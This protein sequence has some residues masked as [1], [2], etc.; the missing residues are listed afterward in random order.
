MDDGFSLNMDVFYPA[1][2]SILWG[3]GKSFKTMCNSCMHISMNNFF[4]KFL[5]QRQREKKRSEYIPFSVIPYSFLSQSVPTCL[6]PSVT[7]Y[8]LLKRTI[9]L[10]SFLPLP[11]SFLPFI[12]SFFVS[13]FLFSHSLLHLPLPL[14]YS[15]LCLFL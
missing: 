14:Q 15:L 6:P 11:S 5:K 2:L 10:H 1:S 12:L 13:L 8:L 7:Q 4:I 3:P 9:K